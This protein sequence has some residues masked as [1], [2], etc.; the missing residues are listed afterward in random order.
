[1]PEANSPDEVLPRLQDEEKGKWL[2]PSVR[3]DK[4]P[5]N[6]SEK[7][8]QWVLLPLPPATCMTLAHQGLF[9]NP[10]TSIGSQPRK[11]KT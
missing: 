6:T 8:E 9:P 11:T 3:G 10:E 7:E 2:L 1:M 5:K 4:A